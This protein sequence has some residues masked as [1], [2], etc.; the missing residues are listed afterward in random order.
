[1][2]NKRF[3]MYHYRQVIARMRLG[4]SDR[5]IKRSDLM[6]R[7]KA[8][9]VREMAEDMGW[10]DPE[11]PL[12]E[13][14][15]LQKTFGPAVSKKGHSPLEPFK[16]Q[17]KTWFEQGIQGTTIFDALVRNHDY[18][19]SYSGVRR[20]IQSLKNANPKASVKLEF[21]PGETAQVDFGSGP[22]LL[23]PETGKEVK[24]WFFVMTLAWSRHMYV[25]QVPD[26]KLETWLGCHQR[27]F[28]FFG[29]VPQKVRV[30]NTKC[31]ITKACFYDPEVQRSY[32]ELACSYGFRIDPCPVA[33]PEKK[34]RVEAGVKYVKKSFF[35]LREI[36]SLAQ[37]NQE[38]MDWVM[39]P[40][41]NRIHGTTKEK[42]LTRFAETEAAFLRPLP[43]VRP[44]CVLW[45]RAVLHGDCHIELDKRYYSAPFIHVG[46][47]LWART[48]E[49][50]VRIYKDHELV[51]T[52]PRVSKPGERSTNYDHYP[53]EAQA[54]LMRDPKWCLTQA[55]RIGPYC[56][57]F[58]V[59]L[60][61]DRVLDKLRAA[62]GLIRLKEK[63]GSKRLEMACKRALAYEAI[64]YRSVKD[65]LKKGLDQHPLEVQQQLPLGEVYT[66]SGKY[67]TEFVQ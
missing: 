66:G 28:E 8:A 6:G 2:A 65:I 32:E 49:K 19:G 54:Y 36:R 25:E 3:D 12:P 35:P 40:A 57:E 1:M 4:D 23:D 30:D 44:E 33:D 60:F 7:I 42:P 13:E 27:A 47:T 18:Q 41:G 17:V 9:E 38:L 24:T 15:E 67:Q 21:K 11:M 16:P 29:G 20:Y 45:S 46:K 37:G 50:M 5:Q 62:Q 10:L 59:E 55:E 63:Y 64:S 22:K 43:L 53:P 61:S 48:T 14:D 58:I 31:A 51:A 34:G 56:L 39:G 26:Q 52:H